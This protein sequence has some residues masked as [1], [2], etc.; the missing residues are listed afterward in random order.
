MA[1]KNPEM[2]E[3]L[4]P[5]RYAKLIA[6]VKAARAKVSKNRTTTDRRRMKRYAVVEVREG[7]ATVEKLMEPL[8]AGQEA[9]IFFMHTGEMY[10]VF[11][12]AHSATGHG[13][14]NVM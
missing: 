2:S 11:L 10:D 5:D 14:R 8:V 3:I 1:I 13:G 7:D 6:E 4:T 12:K 9:N